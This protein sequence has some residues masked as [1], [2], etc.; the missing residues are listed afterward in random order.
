MAENILA[1]QEEIAYN[2]EQLQYYENLYNES[3]N[4]YVYWL[5]LYTKCQSVKENWGFLASCKNKYGFTK[6]VINAN[7]ESS[8][9]TMGSLSNRVKRIKAEI[10]RLQNELNQESEALSELTELETT[11]ANNNQQIAQNKRELSLSNFK[12][13]VVPVVILA[14][15]FFGIYLIRK[16]G[17]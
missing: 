4:N 14:L 2:L 6:N 13:Y 8:Q 1:I 5:D 16:K 3:Y 17:K 15:M 11:I 7:F 10:D 9:T 12:V